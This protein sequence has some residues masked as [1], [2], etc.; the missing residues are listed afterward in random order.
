MTVT[1]TATPADLDP[2]RVAAFVQRALGVLVAGATTQMAYLGDRLGLYRA[3]ASSGPVTAGDLSARTGCAT[4]Y[5]AE[6]L[7]QQSAVGFIDHDP[8]TETFSLPPERAAVLAADDSPAALAGAFEAMAGW[9]LGIDAM[10]EAFRTGTGIS[11]R[12]HDERVD[13]GIARFFGAAYRAHLVDEWVPALGLVSTLRQGA[14][15]ADVGCGFGLTTRL[16]AQAFPNS[17]FVG[18]DV[19]QRSVERARSDAVADGLADRVRFE[20]ADATAFG[21]G[22][23]GLVCFFDCLHDFGDPVAAAAQARR[24][25]TEDG[26]V[27]VVEP[28]ALDDAAENIAGNPGA[29]L[30]YTASTFLCVPHSLSEAGGAALGAQCGGR[31]LAETLAAAGLARTRRVA[32]TPVHAVYAAQP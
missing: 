8:A 19:S 18:F 21:G 24:H 29:G 14:L 27:L 2:E 31:R 5:L 12:E 16:L 3:M 17:R 23:Y 1:N 10:T 4:R 20:V 13:S 26:T 28:F 11:W 32:A 25:L 22:P 6:W 9:Q 30:H 15:V 7:A